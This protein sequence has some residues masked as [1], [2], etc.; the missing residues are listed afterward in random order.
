MCPVNSILVDTPGRRIWNVPLEGGHLAL[1]FV[2]TVGGLRDLAPAPGD[3]ML[4]SYEDLANWC[5]RLGVISE[6]DGRRLLRAAGR[7]A[8]GARRALRRALRLRDLLYAVFRPLA[9]GKQP[10]ADLLDRLRDADRAALA[11]A[12]LAPADGLAPT[13][14]AMRWTWPPPHE[15]PD[16][17][18]PITHAAV[19]LLTSGP[20]DHLKICGNCRWLFLD[21]SRNHSRRWCSMDECGTQMKQRRFVE[22]RRRA[23]RAQE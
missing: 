6:A 20:L 4:V 18:R 11:E 13:G 19:E 16:P 23:S 15:L 12:R 22:R 7:D 1:D 2:N 10:P 21:Q 5:V 9:D 8:K 17:L 14:G 3:E